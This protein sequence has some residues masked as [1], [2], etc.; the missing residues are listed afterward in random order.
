MN[1]FDYITFDQH[2]TFRVLKKLTADSR[3]FPS[4]SFLTGEAKPRK[5]VVVGQS[6]ISKICEQTSVSSKRV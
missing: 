1:I 3:L 4:D 6:G 2:V 5:S